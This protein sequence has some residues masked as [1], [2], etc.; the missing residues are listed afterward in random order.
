[1]RLAQVAT[2]GAVA[3]GLVTAM[4][5]GAAAQAAKT[6]RIQ[7]SFPA[8]SFISDSQKYFA[9]R[10]NLMSGGRLKIEM[11]PVGAVVPAFEV[12]DAVNAGVID[13]GH[14]AI[15]YWLGRNRAATLFG[16]A[17]GGPF[18][19]DMTDYLA[20]INDG[21]GQQLYEEFYK[22]VLKRDIYPMPLIA[23]PNQ[24]LGW[25]KEPITDWA[26][27]KGRKCR[28]AGVTA[29]VYAAA[30]VAAVNVPG[31]EIVPSAER[32]VIECGE[33]AGIAEDI[34]IGFATVW[35]H[36]YTPGTHEPATVLELII[37]G[38][39][40]N[41]LTADLKEIVRTAAMDANMRSVFLI[42]RTNGEAMQDV[43]K[44]GVQVH[45]TPED[46]LIK[47]LEAWDAIAKKEADANPF[48]KK[49]YDSQ[50]A[51]ASKVV[52][53]RRF[54]DVPYSIGANHYWPEK[55]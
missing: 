4:V 9:E 13:G 35:K 1:M 32:G 39:V 49:V 25:F 48:F 34:K 52:P 30:G 55:Q 37:R 41:S 10:V 12:L 19:M 28:H 22:D 21:G 31:G 15:A 5:T 38:R 29:E 42:N 27:L 33:F 18:G 51:Y 54:N 16:P 50:R 3:F 40:W 24:P 23:L 44:L 43:K 36:F 7:S 14:T 45:R 26:S 53:S 8:T 2:A 20:W 46:I 11:L 17:P 6:L 47:S